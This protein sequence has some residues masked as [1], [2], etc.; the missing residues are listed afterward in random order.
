LGDVV[1]DVGAVESLRDAGVV[2]IDDTPHMP[3]HSLEVES[4][5]A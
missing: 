5:L 4:A 2:T 1:V 3:E